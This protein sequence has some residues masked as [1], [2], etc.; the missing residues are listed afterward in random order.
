MEEWGIKEKFGTRTL[1][2]RKFTDGYSI[3]IWGECDVMSMRIDTDTAIFEELLEKIMAKYNVDKRRVAVRKGKNYQ[4]TKEEMRSFE[5]IK[6]DDNFITFNSL[7]DCS[8]YMNTLREKYKP[9]ERV[10]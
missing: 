10:A 3:S 9:Q 7:E 1:S 4:I 6:D 8:K 5:E 2:I